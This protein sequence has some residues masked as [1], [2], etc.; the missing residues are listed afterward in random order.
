MSTCKTHQKKT[1]YR[2]RPGTNDATSNYGHTYSTLRAGNEVNHA[3]A[4]DALRKHL[5]TY[6][7]ECGPEVFEKGHFAIAGGVLRLTVHR[8]R[9]GVQ[10]GIITRTPMLDTTVFM[11]DEE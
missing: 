3:D 11:P 7:G 10:F 8:D 9:H 4:R 1:R 2:F 5:H 6:W